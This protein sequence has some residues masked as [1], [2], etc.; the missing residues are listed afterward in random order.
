MKNILYIGFLTLAVVSLGQ[1]TIQD[2]QELDSS[3]ASTIH[4]A[5]NGPFKNTTSNDTVLLSAYEAMNLNLGNTEL[6]VLSTVDTSK[7]DPSKGIYGLK[8][9]SLSTRPK[10]I[11]YASSEKD[12][13]LK[14]EFMWKFYKFVQSTNNDYQ[15]A[16]DQ[17]VAYCKEK[18]IELDFQPKLVKQE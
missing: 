13:Q 1:G 14:T 6:V 11:L 2:E 3:T 15:V 9:D 17:T 4:L 12:S 10:F 7:F 18:N 5:T 8:S 16:Y